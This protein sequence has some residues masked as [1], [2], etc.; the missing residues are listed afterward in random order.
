MMHTTLF[1]VIKTKKLKH[2]LSKWVV[3]TPG[4]P[5]LQ[6]REGFPIK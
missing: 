2:R 6:G 3:G 1:V 4:V 5:C